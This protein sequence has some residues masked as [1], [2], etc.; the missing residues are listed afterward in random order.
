MPLTV[1]SLVFPHP[2]DNFDE[3]KVNKKRIRHHPR[4]SIVPRVNPKLLNRS[5]M[6]S[7]SMKS[8]RGALDFKGDV[9][10]IKKG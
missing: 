6:L 5:S 8:F 2:P 7:P 9:K 10:A 4:E 3:K 1:P